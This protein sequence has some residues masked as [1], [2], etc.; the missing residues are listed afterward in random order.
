M[1][2]PSLRYASI[3]VIGIVLSAGVYVWLEPVVRTGAKSDNTISSESAAPAYQQ[4]TPLQK[5][6]E[7]PQTPITPRLKS[8]DVSN[9]LTMEERVEIRRDQYDRAKAQLYGLSSEGVTK[10]L[11][12]AARSGD[13]PMF[14]VATTEL[15]RRGKVGDTTVIEA[16]RSALD[17]ATPYDQE[18]LV[19]DVLGYITTDESLRELLRLLD[20]PS[21]YRIRDAALTSIAAIGQY[22]R[23]DP[24][25]HISPQ[26]LSSILEEYFDTI[27]KRDKQRRRS[28]A[29]G[30]L[31]LETPSGREKV[32]GLWSK[33]TPLCEGW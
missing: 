26:V 12:D 22:Y 30:L 8:E 20:T 31:D 10:A 32:G 29:C 14:N 15:I 3:A 33:N 18:W 19:W 11:L 23:L 24:P 27:P 5:E 6:V 25:Q 28:V 1:V 7:Q 21:N 2:Q 13:T 16:I 9:A 4:E 17:Q